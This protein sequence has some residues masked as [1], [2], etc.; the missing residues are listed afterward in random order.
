MYTARVRKLPHVHFVA[1]YVATPAGY[2]SD[3]STTDRLKI[4]I[5]IVRDIVSSV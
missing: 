5:Y 4:Q 3:K 2:S 1:T